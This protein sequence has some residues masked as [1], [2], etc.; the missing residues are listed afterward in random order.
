MRDREAI[1]MNT[2]SYNGFGRAL[3]TNWVP[4]SLI[5]VGVAWLVASNTGLA[6]RV[7][8]DERV[9][10]AGRKIGEFA[11]QFGIGGGRTDEA[12]RAG[13][14][15]GPD[16]EPALRVSDTGRTNGWVH[17][18]AGA[19]RDALSSVR[20]AGGAVLHRASN[21][22]SYASDAGDLAKRAGGQ[23]VEKLEHDPW[24]IGV[25]G[26]V[27]GALLAAV[28]PPTRVEQEFI[29]EAWD[30]LQTRANEIGHEAA[31]RVR[32]LAEATTRSSRYQDRAV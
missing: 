3:Q 25:V 10:A 9:Q 29:G 26:L 6:E 4:L 15:L 30:E 14:I 27:A 5:G 1:D 18:A 22:T 31:D 21:L 19:A 11:G 12:G 24:V 7:A 13:Q 23:V 8:D 20:G 28:L 32:E 16:G 17:Q 2:E